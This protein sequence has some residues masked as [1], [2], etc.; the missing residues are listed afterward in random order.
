MVKMSEQG[1]TNLAFALSKFQE[2]VHNPANTATNPQF[3]SKYAP[4]DVVIN[5]VKPI[6]AKNGL[7]F[8]QSTGAQGESI[9]ITT[10]LLHESGEY[11]ISD[12]L[13]LPAYQL[14]KGGEK[15]FNA[16]GAGSA[17][18]Y[19]RRYSLSAML[20]LSSEDD[21]DGN[22][23]SSGYKDSTNNSA[24]GNTGSDDSEREKRKQEAIK[25]AQERAQANKPTD[26]DNG[27]TNEDKSEK[28][29]PQQE[30]AIG[31]LLNVI[32]KKRGDDFNKDAF[33]EGAISEFGVSKLQEV[34]SEQ[35]K[36]IITLINKEM[37]K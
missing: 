29:S 23:A 35:A 12:P 19:G 25:K 34:T 11:I 2:E 36:T 8:I 9:E 15:D 32:S 1:I 17:I 3:R 20:G 4:L 37:R 24:K 28:I 16:Q 7:S 14:K 13:V 6:L 27:N 18:T 31:N 21:D 26:S 33:L 5:T 10:M 22:V 30:K